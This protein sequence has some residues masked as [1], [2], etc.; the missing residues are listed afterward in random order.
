MRIAAPRKRRAALSMTS[1][2]DVIFLLLLFFMLSSTFTRHQRV[3][4]APSVS[5][6]GGGAP[7]VLLRV[8]PNASFEVNGEVLPAEALAA[9]LE[10]LRGIGAESLVITALDGGDS[11]SLVTAV[12][13]SRRAGFTAVS[14]TD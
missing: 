6:A 5:G 4:I 10:T 8:G 2:I 7:D 14:V 12:E 13:T 1:L 9:R 11:Q 3:D